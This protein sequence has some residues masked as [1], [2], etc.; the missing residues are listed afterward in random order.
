[1]SITTSVSRGISTSRGTACGSAPWPPA[2]TIGGNDGP[3]APESSMKRTSPTATSRSVPPA[4]PRSR[5]DSYAAVASSAAARIEADL[6]LVL[7]RAQPLH[8]PARR[9]QLHAL[10]RLLGE[11]AVRRDAQVLVVEAR[12]GRAGASRASPRM[13]RPTS[14]RSKSGTCSRACST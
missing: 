3:S 5:S 2:A 10:G 9:H 13:S 7:H 6:G 12:R 8:E 14:I 4:S 1:M 11:L